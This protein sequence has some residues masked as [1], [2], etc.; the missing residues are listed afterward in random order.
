MS[1]PIPTQLDGIAAPAVRAGTSFS[2]EIVTPA[3][4]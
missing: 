1:T 3:T 4:P 2:D